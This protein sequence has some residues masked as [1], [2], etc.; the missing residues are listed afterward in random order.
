MTSVLTQKSPNTENA[1]APG[2]RGATTAAYP[3][4]T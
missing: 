1:E 3:C 2:S 4:G